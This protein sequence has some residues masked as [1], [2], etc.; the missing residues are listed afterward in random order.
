MLYLTGPT[1]CRLMR[2]HQVTIRTL[3]AR[4]GVPM[5]R[6][7]LWRHE[8]IADRHAAR[9]WLEAITGQDPGLLHA[10]VEGEP[11]LRARPGA[12]HYLRRIKDRPEDGWIHCGLRHGRATHDLAAVTCQRCQVYIAKGLAYGYR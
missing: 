11:P 10:P 3:A 9:D 5:T 7:R 8:G 6:V 2:R 1:L 4:L 12:I